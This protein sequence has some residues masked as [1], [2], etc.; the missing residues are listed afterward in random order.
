MRARDRLEPEEWL[1]DGGGHA[2]AVAVAR[3]VTDL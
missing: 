1:N 3:P 2:D